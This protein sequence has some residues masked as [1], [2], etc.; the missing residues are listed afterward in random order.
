MVVRQT[1]SRDATVD[2]RLIASLQNF[3]AG[4]PDILSL[5]YLDVNFLYPSSG[6]LSDAWANSRLRAG[7]FRRRSV[8]SLEL[9]I[10]R[11]T[12]GRFRPRTPGQTLRRGVLQVPT[13]RTRFERNIW[14]QPLVTQSRSL[15]DIMRHSQHPASQARLFRRLFPSRHNLLMDGRSCLDLF[16]SMINLPGFGLCGFLDDYRRCA[17]NVIV[18]RFHKRTLCILSNVRIPRRRVLYP[19]RANGGAHLSDCGPP[20][21]LGDLSRFVVSNYTGRDDIGRS[22]GSIYQAT[23]STRGSELGR[24]RLGNMLT[25]IGS[26]SLNCIGLGLIYMLSFEGRVDR[27]V[28]SSAQAW[29]TFLSGLSLVPNVCHGMAS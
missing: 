8:R 13:S 6:R 22:Q 21:E 27:L 14:L 11:E 9:T 26:P 10:L 1:Y 25:V 20:D 28:I 29:K 15:I 18:S 5:G 17:A 24:H 3:H 16:D 12:A 7:S 19:K 2:E 4:L 23:G